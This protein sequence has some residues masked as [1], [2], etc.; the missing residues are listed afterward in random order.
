MRV[1]TAT[2]YNQTKA[3]IG[4]KN[5]GML[6]ENTVISSGKRIQKLSDDPVDASRVTALKTTMDDLQQLQRNV[7]T[8]TLWLEGSEASLVRVKEMI[9]RAKELAIA[10]VNG[11]ANADDMQ[12]AALE[13]GALI[14]GVLDQANT[15]VNGQYIFSGTR[16][17]TRPFMA[18][19]KEQPQAITYRGNAHPFRVKI[20]P[21][22]D[23]KVG[24]AGE[25]IF[26]SDVVV[27]DET[28]NRLDFA[29]KGIQNAAGEE[30]LLS[31][32]VENGAYSREGLA[33]A[34]EMAMERASAKHG[35]G[36][37]YRVSWDASEK[38]FSIAEEEG[39]EP[40]RLSRLSLLFRSGENKNESVGAFMGFEASDQAS[41]PARNPLVSRR[42]VQWGVFSTLFDFKNALEKND[43]QGL[44]Q[45][46]ARL[47]ADHNTLLSSI[48]EAGVRANR[49][50]ARKSLL[51]DLTISHDSNRSR[52]EDADVVKAISDLRLKQF[53]YE[54]ALASS[55][56]ILGTSLLNY[57]K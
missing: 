57:L 25:E 43:Q 9:D 49:L 38:S 27:I 28:S 34:V 40:A 2:L 14:K 12:T 13:V 37:D 10:M 32:V 15:R 33:H 4:R 46:I 22:S 50:D 36:V 26:S 39:I 18:D 30:S 35:N 6:E 31:A 7:D 55:S 16:S 21:S 17:D 29:E 44:H 47:S 56:R 5:R 51:S 19:N 53:G 48:S 23:M 42:G 20:G 3:N 1:A 45:S 11:V 8:G 52:L 54:S 41:E 24:F